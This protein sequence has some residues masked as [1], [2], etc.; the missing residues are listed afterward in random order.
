MI[1]ESQTLIFTADAEDTDA[2]RLFPLVCAALDRAGLDNRLTD[3][4]KVVS[5][6]HWMRSTPQNRYFSAPGTHFC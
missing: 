2:C 4:C 5:L 1:K 3:G 6:K